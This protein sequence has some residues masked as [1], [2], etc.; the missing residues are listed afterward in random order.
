MVKQRRWRWIVGWAILAVLVAVAASGLDWPRVLSAASEAEAGWLAAAVLANASVLFLAT[1][2]WLLFV[3]AGASVSAR[4]MFSIVAVTATVSNGA[5]LLAGHVTGVHLLAT[6][7]GLGPAGG[8]SVTIL[9]QIAEGLAKW[10]LL[11]IAIALV[12]N[13]EYRTSGMTIL[14]GAPA[15]AFGFAVLAHRAD[16]LDRLAREAGGRTRALFGFLSQTVHRL[17]AIRSP[18]LFGL[19]LALAIAKKAAEGLAIA[20][21][22]LA[23]GVDLL[24]WHVVGAVLAVSLSTAVSITPANL[25]VYEGSLVLVFRAAGVETGLALALALL[26][27]VAF[28]L[29]IAGPGLVLESLRIWRGLREDN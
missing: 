7:G 14:L 1:A 17:D 13:F 9:D 11:V 2:E 12:P 19:G 8:V 16:F 27:H 28:L 26:S 25:G 23:L 18:G 29:P 22:A 5:P 6:R 10:T 24:P 4:T 20:A 3:P 15:L 21:I